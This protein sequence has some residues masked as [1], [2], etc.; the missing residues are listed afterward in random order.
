MRG[1]FSTVRPRGSSLAPEQI[2]LE[3][4]LAD[5]PLRCA[6][7]DF[8]SAQLCEESLDALLVCL[9]LHTAGPAERLVLA[10]AL[11]TEFLSDTASRPVN[12]VAKTRHECVLAAEATVAS[13]VVDPAVFRKGARQDGREFTCSRSA[14]SDGG[15]PEAVAG[16]LRR[17]LC[18][19]QGIRGVQGSVGLSPA[20]LGCAQRGR[21]AHTNRR[22]APPFMEPS[23]VP[24]GGCADL[25][26][27]QGALVFWRM[28][29]LSKRG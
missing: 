15:P 13:G 4:I 29:S 3:V 26:A 6:F 22:S 14:N 9:E 25:V 7:A 24:H 8:C 28:V 18:S 16:R 2:T 12:L 5:M 1:L 20:P 17:T 23:Q 10:K 11:L 21:F 27:R 19:L